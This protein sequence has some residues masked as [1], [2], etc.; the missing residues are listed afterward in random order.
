MAGVLAEV[1][2]GRLE[3]FLGTV[4]GEVGAAFNA[5]LVRLGDRL[6]LYRAMAGAG[7]LSAGELAA[8]DGHGGALRARVAVGA[9]RRRVRQLRAAT[10]A[11]RCPPST[12]WC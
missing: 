9:G 6:G 7:P 11:S 10:D 5:A 2:E 4:V 3:R 8:A 12:Q 1:D